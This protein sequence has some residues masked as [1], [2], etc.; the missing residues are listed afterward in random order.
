MSTGGTMPCATWIQ[1]ALG[2][3]STAM[4][5]MIALNAALTPN[6]VMVGYLRNIMAKLENKVD[7]LGFDQKL[8]TRIKRHGV[9]YCH[10]F[11]S[12]DGVYCCHKHTPSA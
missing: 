11:G 2:D 9:Y 4:K 5:D 1:A 6:L 8:D 10:G 7:E 3:H 12:A